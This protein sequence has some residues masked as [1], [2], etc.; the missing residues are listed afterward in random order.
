MIFSTYS[1]YA[2]PL[3]FSLQ[4]DPCLQGYGEQL[5]NPEKKSIKKKY[6]VSF[7]RFIHDMKE[8]QINLNFEYSKQIAQLETKY[9]Y[10]LSSYFKFL[11]KVKI[12]KVY[13]HKTVP[14][15]VS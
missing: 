8:K 6:Y 13:V 10:P 11:P 3:E 15:I 9:F 12:E 14:S 7:V 1:Q 2:S 4:G 5:S